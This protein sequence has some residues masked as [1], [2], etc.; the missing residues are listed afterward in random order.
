MTAKVSG[1]CMKNGLYIVPWYDNLVLAP[2]LIIT[3]EEIDKSMHILDKA[4]T[5]A[6]EEVESTGIA[7]SK[8]AEFSARD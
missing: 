1:E 8:S 4:L 2:P 6:D 7:A 5:I 3:K